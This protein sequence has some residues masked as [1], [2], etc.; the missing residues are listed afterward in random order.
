MMIKLDVPYVS[1]HGNDQPGDCGFACLAMVSRQSLAATIEATRK[2]NKGNLWLS[3][4]ELYR[5]LG[6]LGIPFAYQRF[7]NNGML[8]TRA[9]RT[10]VES[11]F[12]VMVLANYAAVPNRQS[13]FEGAHWFL[14]VGFDDGGF[15]VHDPNWQGEQIER[16]RYLYLPSDLLGQMM[17]KPG[18]GVTVPY[19]GVVVKRPFT[20][21]EYTVTLP[22]TNGIDELRAALQQA[23]RR[24]ETAE[25]TLQKIRQLLL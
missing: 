1:Q 18:S 23:Q 6:V 8:D 15:F 9:L 4:Q 14:I 10:A 13:S 17:A 25:A 16:G 7:G 22:V 21:E 11:R 19:Q 5:C 12:P 3:F 24:A 20:V 2:I